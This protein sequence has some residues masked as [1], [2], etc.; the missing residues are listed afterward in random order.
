MFPR[1]EHCA[2]R[3][4]IRCDLTS[5]VEPIFHAACSTDHGSPRTLE[6]LLFPKRI[7]LKS[8]Y[9]LRGSLPGRSHT[10]RNPSSD[11]RPSLLTKTRQKA[12]TRATIGPMQT[13]PVR[14]KTGIQGGEH[15]KA[16]LLD[17]RSFLKVSALSGGG[18]LLAYYIEPIATG[19]AQVPQTSPRDRK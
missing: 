2:G 8:S 6:R 12:I 10:A 11:R 18:M 9:C 16:T 17:R 3:V 5:C 13:T 15:M 1:F 7:D 14:Q 19:F 4:G